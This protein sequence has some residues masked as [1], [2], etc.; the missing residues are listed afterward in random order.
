MFMTKAFYILWPP[1]G[2]FVLGQLGQWDLVLDERSVITKVIFVRFWTK[3]SFNRD[4]LSSIQLHCIYI[5]YLRYGY[6]LNRYKNKFYIFFSGICAVK[7]HM[8]REAYL[9]FFNVDTTMNE[10]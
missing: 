5:E 9:T 6:I 3:L 2:M 10:K 8:H 4:T 7:Y 1:N